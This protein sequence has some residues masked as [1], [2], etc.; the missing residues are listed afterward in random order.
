M[1]VVS[2]SKYQWLRVFVI[3]AAGI[4]IYY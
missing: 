1:I 2:L 3:Y 4:N